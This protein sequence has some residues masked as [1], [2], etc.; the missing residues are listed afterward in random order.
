MRIPLTCESSEISSETSEILVL[1]N[2]LEQFHEEAEW[3]ECETGRY[4]C[5]YFTWGQGP[6][7]VFIHGLADD[8]TS[9]VLPMSRLSRDFR[10]IGY[11]L[12]T[13]DGDGANLFRYH[14]DDLAADLI[15]LLDHLKLDR[16]YV[17]G[18]SFGSTI[19]LKA[20]HDKPERIPRAILQGGFAYRALSM[21]EHAL[22]SLGRFLPLS[23]Y[24]FPFRKTTLRQQYSATF[25]QREPAIWNYFVERCSAPTMSV[26]A[27]RGW[28][29]TRLDL[30]PLL[31]DIRQPILIICGDRDGL[32][33]H[34]CEVDL[35]QGL[36]RVTRVELEE[37]GH[38]PY[39][40]HPELLAELMLRFLT[41][42]PCHQHH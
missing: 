8:A 2:V 36:P 28:M 27:Q 39:F 16:A 9:F 22:V 19:A 23:M 7:L 29:L 4:R 13:G 11:N 31:A 37:C 17:F 34:G 12:P 20:M 6:P 25:L 24:W 40:T 32:V 41:P 1:D 18:S 33:D 26:L 42:L 14:H 15:A 38:F 5:R 10:C 3:G 30:R 21:A 35:L